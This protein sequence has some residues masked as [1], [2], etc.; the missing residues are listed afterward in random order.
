MSRENMILSLN[1][2]YCTILQNSTIFPVKIMHDVTCINTD[3]AR[4]MSYVSIYCCHF[5]KIIASKRQGLKAKGFF[6]LKM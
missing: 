4:M 1:R 2:E 3:L 5:M 6:N